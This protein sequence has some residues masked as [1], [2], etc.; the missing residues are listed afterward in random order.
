[1]TD[2]VEQLV[3]SSHSRAA[4]SGARRHRV[5]SID[6]ASIMQMTQPISNAWLR[7][8]RLCPAALQLTRLSTIQ[9]HPM[10]AREEHTMNKA[11]VAL[12]LVFALSAQPALAGKAGASRHTADVPKAKV[13]EEPRANRATVADAGHAECKKYFALIGSLVAVPCAR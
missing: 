7:A 12:V 3:L 1:M 8:I 5:L 11:I 10:Q 9:G 13:I 6:W 4:Q 2:A